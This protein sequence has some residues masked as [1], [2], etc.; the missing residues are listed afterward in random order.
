[1]LVFWQEA[2]AVGLLDVVLSSLFRNI[3]TNPIISQIFTFYDVIT[4]ELYIAKGLGTNLPRG[5][6]RG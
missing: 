6:P 1:M 2:Q 4:I 5:T 3:L